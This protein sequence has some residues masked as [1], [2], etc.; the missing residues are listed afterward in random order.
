MKGHMGYNHIGWKGVRSSVAIYLLCWARPRRGWEEGTTRQPEKLPKQPAGRREEERGRRRERDWARACRACT[1]GRRAEAAPVGDARL[2]ASRAG[3][4]PWP[5]IVLKWGASARW[6]HEA[7]GDLA[8]RIRWWR[9]S[10]H[11]SV[12]G[13]LLGKR[14]GAPRREEKGE[15]E[16]A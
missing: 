1:P 9:A 8:G 7:T 2:A 12:G 15:E 14:A 3:H 16:K 5:E 10:R 11:V 4:A 6:G 13:D